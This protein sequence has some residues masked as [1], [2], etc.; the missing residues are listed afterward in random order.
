MAIQFLPGGQE[1]F[2]FGGG[3][4]VI[5]DVDLRFHRWWDQKVDRPLSTD[6][7]G[8]PWWLRET[9]LAASHAVRNIVGFSGTGGIIYAHDVL[10]NFQDIKLNITYLSIS[11]GSDGGG[12]SS[13]SIGIGGTLSYGKEDFSFYVAVGGDST[14]ISLEYNKYKQFQL[15]LVSN[16]KYLPQ[17][18]DENGHPERGDAGQAQAGG[19]AG[20]VPGDRSASPGGSGDP[21]SSSLPATVED[22]A[23]SDGGAKPGG[24]APAGAGSSASAM[25]A[26]D[27]SQLA[28]SGAAPQGREVF[29]SPGAS[30]DATGLDANGSPEIPLTFYRLD[31][32]G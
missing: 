2:S 29:K 24:G 1:V 32:G 31:P 15:T 7:Q 3:G 18:Q 12:D 11:F 9:A 4:G 19:Q 16:D 5:G 21:P 20:S 26:V 30:F 23:A 28:S 17:N 25:P 13:S 10:K 14:G 8:S 27:A 6:L 22:P